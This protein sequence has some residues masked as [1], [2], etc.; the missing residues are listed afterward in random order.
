[1]GAWRQAANGDAHAHVSGAAAAALVQVQPGDVA[2][3]G[4]V[5][6]AGANVGDGEGLRA[7]PRLAGCGVKE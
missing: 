4:P 3:G 1:M 7:R 5:E 2:V 6:L